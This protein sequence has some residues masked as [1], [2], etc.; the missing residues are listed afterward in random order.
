[1][2]IELLRADGNCKND[3]LAT[4]FQF[5]PEAIMYAIYTI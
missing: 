3:F 2:A 1:M 4:S 5:S